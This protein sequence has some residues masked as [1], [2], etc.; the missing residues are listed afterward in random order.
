MK[1]RVVVMISLVAAWFIVSGC[2]R[3]QSVE[4][5]CQE[6][7]E[8]VKAHAGDGFTAGGMAGCLRLGAAEAKR[9]Q[10]ALKK[11]AEQD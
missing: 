3:E 11:M 8:L 10:E 7:S 1:S 2:A 6:T 9:Q 5:I 4:E